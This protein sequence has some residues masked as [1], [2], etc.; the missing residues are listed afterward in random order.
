MQIAPNEKFAC[1]AF[2]H[3]AVGDDVPAEVQ[4]GPRL[5][6]VRQIEI[7]VAEHWRTWLGTIKLEALRDANLTAYTTIQSANPDILDAENAS[8]TG[9][10]GYLL[11]GILLHGVPYFEQTF[12][13]TGA[14]VRGELNI[15]QFGNLKDFQ[16]TPGLDYQLGL[17]DLK[18][19]AWLVD[20]L[21]M[22]NTGGARWARL[23]RG[24]WALFHGT[25]TPNDD[26]DRLHQLVR[27]VEALARP[28]IGRTK[29]Q[30]THR[31][32]QTFTTA[33]A[34]TRQVLEQLFDMRSRVEHMHPVVDILQE[35]DEAARIAAVDRRTRQA[36][37]LARNV[38]LR[39]LTSDA[40]LEQFVTDARIEDFWR[41]ADAERQALWGPRLDIRIV[42]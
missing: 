40:L 6:V 11:Y 24:L 1:Y 7:D 27:A 38:L 31:I 10:L 18:R 22:V 29:N 5:W 33:D 19:S 32:S 17:N 28:D 37:V 21:Q 4:L 15:R 3:F 23:R 16:L 20:R 39:V 41:M 26:G 25:L 34:E 30:F 13:L 12:S 14:H 2:T 36:D 42:E 35:G 8:L 9:T